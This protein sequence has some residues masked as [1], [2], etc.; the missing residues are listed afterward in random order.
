M[1][2]T[3]KNGILIKNPTDSKVINTLRSESE[4]NPSGLITAKEGNLASHSGENLNLA[5]KI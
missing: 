5:M 4:N 1:F 3:E 2:K